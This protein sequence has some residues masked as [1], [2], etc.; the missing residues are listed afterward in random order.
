[1]FRFLNTKLLK[2]NSKFK[3]VRFRLFKQQINGGI[4][5]DCEVMAKTGT[6]YM[7]YGTANN[8]ARISAGLEIIRTFSRTW[9]LQMPVFVDNAESITRLDTDGLQVIRLVVSEDDKTLRI[10]ME[11][12]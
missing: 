7:P 3:N 2:I 9:G 1:M 11:E 4:I 12:N 5:D 10:E 6:G 8:A